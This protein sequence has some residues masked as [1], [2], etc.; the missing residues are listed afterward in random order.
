MNPISVGFWGAFFGCAALA[1]I[2]CG[3]AF[4]RSA[5]RVAIRGGATAVLSAA[6]A[7]A[8]LGW[9]P[10]VEGDAL[11]RLRAL[12]AV[13]S[14]AVLAMLL[15]L[16][17][18][19]FRRAAWKTAGP[20]LVAVLAVFAF[21]ICSALPA[22]HALR[23]AVAA[24]A[25]AAA[26][27][28]L[29][30]VLSARRG[31]RV[32]L[33]ALAALPCV[34]LSM[35]GLDWYVF[36]PEG[37]PW[38]LLAAS[39]VAGI[40]YLLCIATAMW[41]RYAYLIEVRKVMTHG[42]N[43]D[44][45]S[46]MPLYAVGA[47]ATDVFPGA[48]ARPL[49][50]VAISIANLKMLEDLHGRAAY[51]HAIFVCATRLR[52]LDFAGTELGRLADEGF[53]IVTRRPESGQQLIGQARQALKRLSRPV[54]LGTSRKAETFEEGEALWEPVLGIG[55]LL[56]AAEV[57]PELA[58]AGARDISRSAWAFSSCMGWYDE[59]EAAIA[60]IPLVD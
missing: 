17:L 5:R 30:A 25:L 31:E 2:V 43:Y 20:R 54:L 6:Y 23:F 52:S 27:A 59:Q 18:G 7:L 37:T 56:E 39:A 26:G 58:I 29:S 34:S 44:P 28:L 51:N 42:S 21:G 53:L 45:L 33:L 13:I 12:T 35:A 22:L 16:L 46:G 36:H 48:A 10:G 49:G 11:Q 19:T 40:G 14:A 55:V 38:Q 47:P 15:F 9:V 1:V 24:A 60:Q 8:F 57:P 32:G 41:T 4:A 50:L 3:L